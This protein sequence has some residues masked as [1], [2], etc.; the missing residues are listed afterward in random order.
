MSTVL[1]RLSMLVFGYVRSNFQ[2]KQI[3]PTSIIE[4][5]TCFYNG[6]IHWQIRK[7]K[8]LARSLLSYEIQGPSLIIRDI[9]L[10]LAYS[11]MDTI[12]LKM[13]P[14]ELPPNILNFVL[15]IS[16]HGDGDTKQLSFNGGWTKD[17]D[18][19]IQFVPE[20]YMWKCFES[21][22]KYQLNIDVSLS[23]DIL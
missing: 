19:I 17:C 11:S 4:M 13:S 7:P 10:Q 23:V 5:L 22:T 6:I 8:V 3:V 18:N 12:L 14:N 21:I 2:S 1:E 15:A 9:P 16:L 20:R